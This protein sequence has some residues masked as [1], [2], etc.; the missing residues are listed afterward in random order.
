MVGFGLVI[1]LLAAAAYSN[2][3]RSRAIQ[4]EASRLMVQNQVTDRLMDGLEREQIAATNLL[5]RLSRTVTVEDIQ[6]RRSEGSAEQ[7]RQEMDGLESRLLEIAREGRA[8]MP[9]GAWDD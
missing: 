8:S 4:A 3:R 1:L 7:L 5:L 6:G 2:L 9:G